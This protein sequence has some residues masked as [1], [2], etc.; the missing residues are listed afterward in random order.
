[1]II[2]IVKIKSILPFKPKNEAPVFLYGEAPVS[3]PVSFQRMNSPAPEKFKIL[4][5]LLS[6]VN[7]FKHLPNPHHLVSRQLISLVLFPQLAQTFVPEAFDHTMCKATLVTLK[8][9]TN[10]LVKLGNCCNSCPS[11]SMGACYVTESGCFAII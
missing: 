9:Q 3:F 5:H 10:M 8:Y 4:R 11:H 1:M 7:Q 2:Q 6:G